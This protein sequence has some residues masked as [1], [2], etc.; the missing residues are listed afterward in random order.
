VRRALELADRVGAGAIHLYAGS[1]LGLLSLGLG[2]PD[3]A[4]HSLG[5][6]QRLVLEQGLEEPGTV[7][8]APDLIESFVQLGRRSEAEAALA[9]FG[10][11]ATRTGRTW[12]LAAAARCRGLL[13]TDN[14]FDDEFKEA[15]SWHD[16]T[17]TPFERARTELAY[18]ERLR[19][20]G[21]RVKAREQLRAALAAF[22]GMGVPPWAER[23]RTEL[24]A[25]GEVL[26]TRDD[27]PADELTAQELQ[28]ALVVAGGA[29][30]REAAA[31]LFLSPK[32]IEFHLGHI[33]RKLRLRSRT[34]LARRFASKTFD[35][36]LVLLFTDRWW[37]LISDTT[38]E[39]LEAI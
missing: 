8:W 6:L 20:A 10:E 7:Q 21:L 14:G 1:V 4:V 30:N 36:V 34:E 5:P 25:S 18:G 19:R 39:M 27:R 32:T 38:A 33:F 13:A 3:E 9:I 24:R 12:A 23:A 31:R 35:A 22:E 15:L 37:Y 11:Q 2:R 17:P 29:T 26:R 28:V 16:R